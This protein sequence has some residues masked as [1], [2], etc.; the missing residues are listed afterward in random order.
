MIQCLNVEDKMAVLTMLTYSTPC[1][2]WFTG[3]SQAYDDTIIISTI[4]LNQISKL[5]EFFLKGFDL[6]YKAAFCTFVFEFFFLQNC[7]T[8]Y[9]KVVCQETFN[10]LILNRVIIYTCQLFPSQTPENFVLS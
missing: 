9:Y 1:A 4:V 3:I 10:A 8:D 6:S 2:T 5:T 7:G